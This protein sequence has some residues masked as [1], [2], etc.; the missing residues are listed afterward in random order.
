MVMPAYN[1]ERY[2]AEA[3]ESVL[4]QT[5]ANLELIVIDD[6]SLDRTRAIAEQYTTLDPR[7]RVTSQSNAGP[8]ATMNRGLAEASAEWVAVMHADDVMMPHRIERQMAFVE[9]H[10]EVAVASGWVKHVDGEGNV[11]AKDNNRLLTHEAVAERFNAGQLIGISHPAAILRKSAVLAIGGYREQL[12][13]NEDVD[14]WARLLENGYKI[15]VQPEFLLGYRIHSGSAS[16]YKARQVCRHVHWVKDCMRRRRRGEAEITWEEFLAKRRSLPW[17]QRLNN[18]RKDLAKVYYKAATY[19]FAQR[20]YLR[21][22]LA[23]FTALLLQPGYTIPQIA[24]KFLF[25]RR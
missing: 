20:R 19:E 5:W 11:I 22:F 4:H 16:I 25:N 7:V 24:T 10:P 23:A 12:R 18:E 6:G 8:S 14:L 21:V 1:A 2:I 15:L 9:Q 3:I 17:Y 13:I